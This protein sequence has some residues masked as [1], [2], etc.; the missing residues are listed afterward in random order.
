MHHLPS[1]PALESW[2]CFPPTAQATRFMFKR[3]RTA[4]WGKWKI[5]HSWS[6]NKYGRKTSLSNSQ[7]YFAE[8]ISY[9]LPN[10][11]Q[12]VSVYQ[13]KKKKSIHCHWWNFEKLVLHLLFLNCFSTDSGVHILLQSLQI[14]FQTYFLPGF[15]PSPGIL[16][17]WG[18]SSGKSVA[19]LF[20]IMGLCL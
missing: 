7:K 6:G 15:G 19:D 10:S 13:K 9:A 8:K 5:Y 18:K 12:I 3:Q 17:T 4:V 2:M 14:F 1:F 20:R 16:F 11:S